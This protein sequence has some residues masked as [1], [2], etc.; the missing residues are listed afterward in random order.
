MDGFLYFSVEQWVA[1]H[2][3]DLSA[4]AELRLFSPEGCLKGPAPLS[5]L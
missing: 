2:F 1:G 3:D 4:I 5:T